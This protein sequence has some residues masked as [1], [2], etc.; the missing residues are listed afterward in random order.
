MRAYI[1]LDP[2]L[3]DHKERYSDGLLAAFLLTF[4]FCEHQPERGTFRNRG[5]LAALLGRRARYIDA[6]LAA[7]DLVFTN[8]GQLYFEGWREC[9]EGNWQV[10]ERMKR[11]RERKREKPSVTPV[12][13]STVTVSSEPLAVGGKP[14]AVGILLPSDDPVV[15]LATWWSEK[16]GG[17]ISESDKISA[18]DLVIEAPRLAVAGIQ[19]VICQRDEWLAENG[20]R[21]YRNLGA[22][23]EAVRQA[24]YHLADQGVTRPRSRAHTDSLDMERAF[25]PQVA[26]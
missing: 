6:L 13:P 11:V 4:C 26:S 19:A 24:E 12:T 7:G 3:P 14:L 1:R 21:P 15:Q 8:D 5:V 25:Q 2:K 18:S 23:I 9:Q 20:K 10:A 17:F 22:Y 16:R